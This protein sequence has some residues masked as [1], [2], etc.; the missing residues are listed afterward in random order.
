MSFEQHAQAGRAPTVRRIVPHGQMRFYPHQV[1]TFVVVVNPLARF[2]MKRITTATQNMDKGLTNPATNEG[3]EYL[4][5]FIIVIMHFIQLLYNL[6]VVSKD[7][8][9]KR[10]ILMF[11][12]WVI[13]NQWNKG[14][15]K[16]FSHKLWATT[17]SNYNIMHHCD[18]SWRMNTTDST[19]VVSLNKFTLFV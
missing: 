1:D 19:D 13:F 7:M 8:S 3:N 15:V 5:L 12:L 6:R 10:K 4:R 11:A 16:T 9:E 17:K 18:I 14:Y 2:S